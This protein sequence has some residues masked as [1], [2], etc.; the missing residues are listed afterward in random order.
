M[1]FIF[2]TKRVEI[3]NISITG[4]PTKNSLTNDLVAVSATAKIGEQRGEKVIL[5]NA[6]GYIYD[7]TGKSIFWDVSIACVLYGKDTRRI[8]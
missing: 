4:I 2:V 7:F 5:S 1:N 8:K 3:G 6:A